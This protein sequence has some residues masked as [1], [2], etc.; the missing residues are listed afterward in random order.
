MI[1]VLCWYEEGLQKMNQTE[2]MRES[3][4]LATLAVTCGV[5]SCKSSGGFIRPTQLGVSNGFDS[6][7]LQTIDTSNL[8]HLK[9]TTT[10]ID[11]LFMNS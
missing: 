2:L 1:E 8:L 7:Q 11:K 9:L 5:S 4:A 10:G 6:V 3:N